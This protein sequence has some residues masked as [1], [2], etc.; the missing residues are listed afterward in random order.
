[1][2]AVD[3]VVADALDRAA[4]GFLDLGQVSG[5]LAAE[6][7]TL[8]PASYDRAHLDAVR[9]AV[10]F[11]LT[12]DGAFHGDFEGNCTTPWP[13]VLDQVSADV[14]GVWRACADQARAAALRA[15][16][17]DLLTSA[18]FPWNGLPLR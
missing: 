15:H 8:N 7:E 12:A 16:L 17:Y 4:D 5:R 14:L 6:A 18:G 3:T 13:R 1:M 2:T 11:R 10:C 9:A